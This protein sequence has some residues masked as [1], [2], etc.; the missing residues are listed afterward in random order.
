M[1]G[2][3][4]AAKQQSTVVLTGELLDGTEVVQSVGMNHDP[5]VPD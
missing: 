5:G 3:A 2:I 1:G 4:P